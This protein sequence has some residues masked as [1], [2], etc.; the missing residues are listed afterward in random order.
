MS[1]KPKQSEREELIAKLVDDFYEKFDSNKMTVKS[2]AEFAADFIL[3][4]RAS[5]E[6]AA[7]RDELDETFIRNAPAFVGEIDLERYWNDYYEKRSKRLAPDTTEG[8]V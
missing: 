4:D 2:F 7:R 8:G 3:T 1:N 6:K 5:A